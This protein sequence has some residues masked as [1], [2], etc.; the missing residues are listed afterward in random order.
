MAKKVKKKITIGSK[1]VTYDK[2]AKA[3]YIYLSG[4]A[5][6]KV[7]SKEDN[8]LVVIDRDDKGLAVGI[9]IIGIKL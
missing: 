9:E 5:S 6:G 7:S 2:E 1:V 3:L 4:D 8:Y